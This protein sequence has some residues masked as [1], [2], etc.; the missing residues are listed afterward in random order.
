MHVLAIDPGTFKSAFIVFNTQAKGILEA[1]IVDNEE[2]EKHI[3]QLSW[4]YK[5]MVVEMVKSYG[6]VIGDSLLGTCVWIGRFIAYNTMAGKD[7]DL[8]I[9]KEIVNRVC[10]NSRAS[11]KNVRQALID[12]YGGTE[13]AI[14][15]KKSPGPLY[16]IKKD[17]WSAL[18]IAIAW[19]EKQEVYG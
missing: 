13:I 5:V 16:G 17:L 1:G 3:R 18:A 19:C 15:N 9:R 4:L 14:G 2:L 6:N 10:H 11:D 7:Y 12:L 8:I